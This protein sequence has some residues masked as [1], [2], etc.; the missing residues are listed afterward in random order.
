M[1]IS[2]PPSASAKV[3]FYDNFETGNSNQWNVISGQWKVENGTYIGEALYDGNEH[4]A[5]STAGSDTWKNYI[6]EVSVK[7]IEGVDKSVEFRFKGTNNNY[8]LNL[9]SGY[10]NTGNDISLVK[11][12]PGGYKI[13][14]LN[15]IT[16]FTVTNNQWYRI[17]IIVNNTN[18]KAYVDDNPSPLLEYNDTE[19]T[20]AEGKICLQIWPG[21]YLG[22]GKNAI[23]KTAYDDISVTELN[24]SP[25][26]P[27][28]ILLP[29][30][31]ASFSRGAI[32]EGKNVGPEDWKLG[33]YIKDYNGLIQ[34]IKNAGY[35]EGEDFFVFAYDWRKP[36]SEISQVFNDFIETKVKPKNLG[37]KINLVGHSLGGLVA[38]EYSQIHPQDINKI[39]TL[40]SPHG[41]V[42]QVYKPWEGGEIEKD[43]TW[44]WLAL[45]LLLLINKKGFETDRQTIKATVPVVGDLLPIFNFLKD[46]KTGRE[47]NVGSM[48]QQNTW[49][50]NLGTD[51]SKII[52]VFT[53]VFGQKWGTPERLRVIPRTNLDKILGNY[54]D[55][56]PIKT[57]NGDG[58]SCVLVKSG[59]VEGG[60]SEFLSDTDHADLVASQ[61]GIQKIVD[62]LG[63][64][65]SSIASSPK[66]IIS[67]SLI[68]TLLSPASFS[69]VDPADFDHQALDN[70]LLIENP[71]NGAYKIKVKPQ[72]SGG[73]YRLLVG[74]ITQKGDFWSE[75]QNQ[76]GPS[77][78]Q[79]YLINFNKDNPLS[80]PLVDQTGQDY[81]KIAKTIILELKKS[82]QDGALD[83][84][85]A[86]IDSA[87]EKSR[88]NKNSEAAKNAK[89]AI[90]SLFKFRKEKKAPL[91]FN[92]SLSAVDN[93][94]EAY[95]ILM[96]KT[97]QKPLVKMIKADWQT[98]HLLL[99][100]CLKTMERIAGL[101]LVKKEA[102]LSLSE[103][104]IR[105][106]RGKEAM[107]KSPYFKTQIL[108][109]VVKLL[110]L[111]TRR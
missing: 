9:R 2:F 59:Q 47:I 10:N 100:A 84:A 79:E 25:S 28:L 70:F 102:V 61:K 107:D 109:Q 63:I 52:S 82:Y 12:F 26:N 16:S 5:F 101:G 56:R 106:Q 6:F 7:G 50:K 37:Q 105:D 8:A 41:G 60:Q 15:P 32:L 22:P 99:T 23:T 55:G 49:L 18:I 39:I 81:L 66:T 92:L 17:K 69:V 78:T 4:P 31:M 91:A 104:E 95:T 33:A 77:Q 35:T 44:Q 54:E 46:E 30:L 67:P 40:G 42:V 87:I 27:P 72:D 68:F 108:N 74:Q 48:K 3:L 20:P 86:S 96:G 34:T 58:D 71:Q 88:N 98:T 14:V 45:K 19:I 73:S 65:P 110:L 97:G 21:S 51:F 38:R 11:N 53:A 29:G 85:L 64:T 89:E 80:Q 13:L 93:L 43:N 76:I 24:T 103:A 62:L 83:S 57:E 90:D 94:V 1:A 111:E 36:V 75:Y